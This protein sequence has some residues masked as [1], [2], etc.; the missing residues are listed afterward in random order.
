MS[1]HYF[2]IRHSRALNASA[3]PAWVICRD[4]EIAGPHD[5]VPAGLH[6]IKR[7]LA[8]PLP[9]DP[10]YGAIVDVGDPLLAQDTVCPMMVREHDQW[11]ELP[12]R[13]HWEAAVEFR[14][15]GYKATRYGL[16][17]GQQTAPTLSAALHQH[18]G[19]TP[20]TEPRKPETPKP[21]EPT[22]A[23]QVFRFARAHHNVETP[24]AS[25]LRLAQVMMEAMREYCR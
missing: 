12:K 19:T 17:F 2:S 18:Y 8:D 4:G 25:Q 16:W 7:L 5:D 15:P 3:K 10:I 20:A 1:D 23:E 11:I 21:P 24:T 13:G 22:P 14:R 9:A 6:A